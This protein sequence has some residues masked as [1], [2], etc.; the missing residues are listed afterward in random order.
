M[1]NPWAKVR[2]A[3][4]RA[5]ALLAR[6]RAFSDRFTVPWATYAEA[7]KAADAGIAALSPTERSLYLGLLNR[8]VQAW[9][10]Y[11]RLAGDPQRFK[12]YKVRDKL[13]S[14][15]SAVRCVLPLPY[16]GPISGCDKDGVSLKYGRTP[17]RGVG[18]VEI[19]LSNGSRRIGVYDTEAFAPP[20]PTSFGPPPD[21]RRTPGGYCY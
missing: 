4:R 18:E 14:E 12:T 13:P 21:F 7:E 17:S 2:R 20:P 15:P 19:V 16:G 10:T 3:A 9:N 1:S 6:I 5:N 11:A 8:W